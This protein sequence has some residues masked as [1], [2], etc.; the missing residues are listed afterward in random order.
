MT[1]NEDKI[2]IGHHHIYAV[3][4]LY[5]EKKLR[6]EI[7]SEEHFLYR[8]WFPSN[9]P[10]FRYLEDY[11][12]AHPEDADM[13]YVRYRLKDKLIGDTTYYALYFGKS[14]DGRN[15]FSQHTKGPV[16]KSTLR[17]T[18]RAI[19]A[20]QGLPCSETDISKVLHQCYYE[21]MEF[22]KEDYELIDSFETMAIAIGYYPL[23]LDGNSSISEPWK[24]AI[25]SKRKDMKNYK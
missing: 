6:T 11:L 16:K 14:I 21:W 23:N 22:M 5:D 24:N 2:R 12:K 8:W 17:E 19:L 1:M 13:H 7:L 25:L 3:T 4:D 20:M 9:S 18:L 15:R 10:I